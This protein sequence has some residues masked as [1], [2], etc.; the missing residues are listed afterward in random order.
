MQMASQDLALLPG[1]GHLQPCLSSSS[2]LVTSPL[3]DCKARPAPVMSS[4][5]LGVSC[6]PTP[7]PR[8]CSGTAVGARLLSESCE[9]LWQGGSNAKLPCQESLGHTVGGQC[10][11]RG[12]RGSALGQLWSRGLGRPTPLLLSSGRLA[13]REALG[14]G[15]C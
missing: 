7:E 1:T 8:S 14:W 9:T 4:L 11:R 12:G 5:H 2:F 3:A 13:S 10:W 15:A 6:S